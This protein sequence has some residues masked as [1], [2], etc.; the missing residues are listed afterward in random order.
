M[1]P[2][3]AQV[4]SSTPIAMTGYTETFDDA[5]AMQFLGGQIDLRQV[6]PPWAISVADGRLSFRNSANPDSLRYQDIS[7]VKYPGSDVV[8]STAGARITAIVQSEN[9][10]LG[11]AGILIGSGKN[12]S[13]FMFAID[14]RGQYYLARRSGRDLRMVNID[15]D[16]A[17]L[18]GQPNEVSFHMS[19]DNIVFVVNG[20]PVVQVA[21]SSQMPGSKRIGAN[22]EVGIAAFGLG[23]Y[24]FDSVTVTP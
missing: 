3:Q 9:N 5:A 8:A 14:D 19:G 4:V 7:W 18:P 22:A 10:G 15:Y 20:Q 23:M 1:G 16:T 13:Y 24:H 12:G 2:A 21:S 17:I 6:Q 11:G